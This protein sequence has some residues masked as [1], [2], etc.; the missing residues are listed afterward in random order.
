MEDRG[1]ILDELLEEND[2]LVLENREL[3]GLLIDRVFMPVTPDPSH[4]M[5]LEACVSMIEHGTWP[6][7][8]P[9]GLDGVFKVIEAG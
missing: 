8:W 6:D 4:L 5:A 1:R 2:R 7:W 9:H 3:R